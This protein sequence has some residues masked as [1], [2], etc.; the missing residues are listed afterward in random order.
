[1]LM[2]V[3][4]VE[5]A[6]LVVFVLGLGY[7]ITLAQ[8]AL[9]LLGLCWL[10]RLR[11]PGRWQSLRFP[12]LAPGLALAAVTILAAL[13]S[14]RPGASLRDAKS[15]LLLGTFY[16][17]LHAVDGPGRA[18]R[19]LTLLSLSLGSVAIWG[20]LQVTLCPSDPGFLPLAARFF[21]RCD[22]AHAFYSIYMT[23][24][25]VL[26]LGLLALL[27]RILPGSPDRRWWVGA[28]CAVQAG[29]LALTHVRGAWVGVGVGVAALAVMARR[30]RW[31]L[32]A[33][34]LGG[35][36][37]AL[38]ATP[39]LRQRAASIIDPAD[40]TVRERWFI[41]QSALRIARDHPFLGVGPGL[42]GDV[43]P[44]YAELLA[45]RTRRG[46]VH[47]T[48]LQLLIERGPLG[49]LAWLWFFAAFF[50]KGRRWLAR[51][52]PHQARERALVVGGLS[53]TIGFLV[54]GLFE[55]N[56]GDSEVLMVAYGIMAVA[57][58]AM[59][60]DRAGDPRV[61]GPR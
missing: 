31:A 5:T 48:P 6:L 53:A 25:G 13:A 54:A 19:F 46:H 2:I 27:P 16:L 4:R 21:K 44:R 29:A 11:E 36:V 12:L 37:I 45:R 43:Y 60:D 23:L 50:T 1:M 51:R 20:I 33:L 35:A 15:L 49:L 40:P 61:A 39:G 28:A 52:E 47:N 26:S 30:A 32:L 3:R 34:L 41:W 9:A 7:S 14:A 57:C 8:I 22:R 18:H 38:V 17:V 55:Y 58:A 24:A 10:A 56:F 59:G 42:V